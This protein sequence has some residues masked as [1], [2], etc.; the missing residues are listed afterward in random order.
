M[1]H[2]KM[3]HIAVYLEGNWP[4]RVYYKEM[5]TYLKMEKK[6]YLYII[7]HPGVRLFRY[8]KM[9]MM[10]CEQFVCASQPVS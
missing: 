9:P 7:S 8:Q 2:K 3:I 6:V 1:V 4:R 5:E 10:T